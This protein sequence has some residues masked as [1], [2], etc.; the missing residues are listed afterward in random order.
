MKY[1]L[2]IL[3]LSSESSAIGTAEFGSRLACENA[4][5]QV[6]GVQPVDRGRYLHAPPLAT[7]LCVEKE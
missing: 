4:A 6:R 7:A 5:A 2:L 3:W 1:I